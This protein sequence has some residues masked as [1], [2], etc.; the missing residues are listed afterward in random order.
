MSQS[1]F[2]LELLNGQNGFVINGASDNQL[3]KSVSSAGDINGDGIDDFILGAP[4][5]GY[6]YR[7]DR[8]FPGEAYVFFGQSEFPTNF[9][10]NSLDGNN[11]F[12]LR[13]VD[14][15]DVTGFS[16][17]DGGDINGDGIADLIIGAPEAGGQETNNFGTVLGG[18]QGASYVVFGSDNG[19]ESSL[20]LASLDGSNGFIVSGIDVGDRLGRSVSSVGDFNGDGFDDL[21]L[22]APNLSF[23][24]AEEEGNSYLIFG[25][26]D[27]SAGV[28]LTTLDGNNGFI[29]SGINAKDNSGYSV[30]GGGDINGDGFTDLIIGAPRANLVENDSY[31]NTTEGV[32]YVVF[33]GTDVGVEGSF[34]L[35]NLDGSNG[36]AINGSDTN[37]SFPEQSGFSVSNAGDIN[38]DGFDDVIIG[39]SYAGSNGR[40]TNETYVVFGRAEGFDSSLDLST[41]DGSNGFKVE[42]I[43]GYSVS[44]AGDINGD[45]LDDI[46]LGNFTRYSEEYSLP[47]ILFGREGEFA[48]VI[49]AS[50]FDSDRGFI[51]NS[52]SLDQY[53]FTEGS[54]SGAGDVNQD[55]IDDFIIGVP[56]EDQSYVVFGNTSS[57]LDLNGDTPGIESNVTYS[58][59][60]IAIA[61]S[62]NLTV[63]NP[64]YPDLAEATVT[65]KN[66]LDGSAEILTAETSGTNITANY[67]PET[68][69][70]TLEGIDT[71]TNYQQVLRTVTYNNTAETPDAS[72]RIIEFFA[73]NGFANGD[74]SATTYLSFTS[75]ISSSINTNQ[76]DG[77]NGFVIQGRESYSYQSFSVNTAGDFNGDSIEDIII[78][79]PDL[80]ETFVIFGGEREW[81]ANFNPEEIAQISDL[82]LLGENYEA[83]SAGDINGD[84]FDDIISQ[85]ETYDEERRTFVEGKTYVVF[86]GKELDDISLDN[87]DGNNGFTI[88]SEATSISKIGD[89]NG[90]RIDDLIIG[91]DNA[92]PNGENSGASFIIF[93]QTEGFSAN[94]DTQ[95]LDGSNGFVI[96]GSSE[97]E[98]LGRAVSDIGDF[99]GD[100]LADVMVAATGYSANEV[101]IIFGSEGEFFPDL[102]RNSLNGD[103]GFIL[104]GIEIYRGI[105]SAGDFNGDGLDDIIIGDDFDNKAYVV[106]GQREVLTPRLDLTT[107]DGNN[108][109]ILEGIAQAGYFDSS[110]GSSV[111]SNDVNGDG[112][113]DLIIGARSVDANSE[114]DTGATYIIFGK[115]DF[116]ANFNLADIDGNNGFIFTGIEENDNIGAFANGLGDFNNDGAGDFV[117]G[118]SNSSIGS[119]Q[120]RYIVFGNVSLRLD[121]NGSDADI[122]FE[123]TFTEENIAIV[124]SGLTI[125]SVDS[126]ELVSATIQITNLLDE[127]N[128]T[129]TADTANTNI[130]ATYNNA[131]GTLTLEG[132]DSVA[133]YQQVLQTLTYNNTAET[134][135]R[136]TRRIEFVINDGATPN[137]RSALA[138][139]TVIIPD[140]D[141][142]PN[143]API[144]SNPIDDLAIDSDE[145]LTFTLA[146]DTFSDEDRDELT[147]TATLENGNS[148]PYWLD[149]NPDTATFSGTPTVDDVGTINVEVT[150]SDRDGGTIEET[151]ELTVNTVF[152]PSSITYH[153]N[154][155][156]RLSG[157]NDSVSL[158]FD[159]SQSDA[160]YV[161]EVGVFTVDDDRGTIDG[162][163]PDEPGYLEAALQKARV[164]FST[165]PDNTFED[166]T[167]SRH[168]NFETD[169]NLGFL[170]VSNSSIETALTDLAEGNE[171]A[172]VLI[173]TTF[174]VAEHFDHLQVTSES[175]ESDSLTLAW[176]DLID[177]GDRDFNDLVMSVAVTEDTPP[178]NNELQ[179]KPEGEL[180]DLRNLSNG[181]NAQFQ[182]FGDSI[183]ENTAGFYVVE[184]RQGT[185]LDPLT[186][187][188]LLPEDTEYAR[189]A[190]ENRLDLSLDLAS[191]E[192]TAELEGGIIL[193]PYLISNGTV[194]EFL[195]TNPQNQTNSTPLAYFPHSDANPDSIDHIRLL[196]DNQFGFEDLL[197]GGDLDYNDFV[198]Q[199]AIES[200]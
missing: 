140:R 79:I 11:G 37:S 27:F 125:E 138:A 104:E 100:G 53:R 76:I 42:N 97:S 71:V 91:D 72:Q 162:I 199:V 45:G 156:F 46:I 36:F 17:S 77:S 121:L 148:L 98:S 86:G 1:F 106:F 150:A 167:S 40:N 153:D 143:Q 82:T 60:P 70:L 116:S 28:D 198:L 196:G 144:V 3:G 34:D 24:A 90:D 183:Y 99:N 181:V 127:D 110:F 134:P 141:I 38:G 18:L 30:S 62:A 8:S 164:V 57:S 83:K 25:R 88:D 6:G 142:I 23:Q 145:E 43:S 4:G 31:Y 176:E 41:L 165:L 179:D 166:F 184:D 172:N 178:L 39:A 26:E 75:G 186:G 85:G 105:I 12:T 20:E 195:S 171:P 15:E 169:T 182:V 108:G 158:Q 120:E 187:E 47:Y 151:F 185:I 137:S 32:S 16:V 19:F 160:V 74:T 14:A 139:T 49:D 159:L 92:S 29:I 147:L 52:S 22:G 112:L 114:S 180:I 173:S 64:S 65:I 13:G 113:S 189:V 63:A 190:L 191:Q 48:P 89:F 152:E 177:G 84:G 61:D 56:L 93:G 107:L 73:T 128:E 135:N 103:N 68:G 118:N 194:E 124:D 136:E 132:R 193:A 21:I 111:S 130:T 55:G 149:F 192:R 5:Q 50:D 69:I 109:F 170:L 146:E 7:R 175:E 188:F 174:S 102:D 157:T 44:G 96:R 168:L 163:A 67:D 200:L 126:A 94:L 131:T 161:N 122:N 133:N 81:A 54:V 129:L 33:G 155:L 95:D 101:Y 87:L 115:P 197:G 35:S 9:D 117:V 154:H 58:G 80:S 78:N 119:Y 51:V 2:D 66:L 123:T 59:L 10:I